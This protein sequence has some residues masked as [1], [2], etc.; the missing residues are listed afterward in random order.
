[1]LQFVVL[2]YIQLPHKEIL[3]KLPLLNARRQNARQVRNCRSCK[4][5]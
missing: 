3:I 5:P 2:W 4:N 1:M